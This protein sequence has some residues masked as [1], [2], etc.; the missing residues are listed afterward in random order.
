[1]L[2]SSI[3]HSKAQLNQPRTKQRSTY[4]V[5]VRIRSR[6]RKQAYV[7]LLFLCFAL[8]LFQLF[9]PRFFH[10]LLH[11]APCNVSFVFFDYLSHFPPFFRSVSS[12]VRYFLEP[13]FDFFPRICFFP[14]FF[15]RFFLVELF[16][17]RTSAYE[18]RFVNVCLERGSSA[19]IAKAHPASRASML[20]SIYHSTAQYSTKQPSK[21]QSAVHRAVN[22]SESDNAGKHTGLARVSMSSSICN[23]LCSQNQRRNRNMSGQKIKYN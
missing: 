21:A 16:L 17:I 20:S 13:F 8:A 10:V 1:M 9:P 12:F 15:P 18:S 19:Q 11:D 6:Q 5:Y 23:S 2:S 7:F 22:T 4:Q 3:Y 14:F